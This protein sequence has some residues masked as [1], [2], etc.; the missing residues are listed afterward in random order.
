MSKTPVNQDGTLDFQCEVCHFEHFTKLDKYKAHLREH[1]KLTLYKCTFCDKS[2]S[3]SSN[4][5]KHKKIH[6]ESYLKCDLCHRKFN[7]KKMIALHMEYHRNNKPV[8]CRHCSR[9]FHFES[10]LKKHVKNAHHDSPLSKF[11]CSFCDEI[12]KSLREK[13]DHEWDVHNVRKLIVDCLICG[14]KFRK[15]SQLKRHCTD[16]HNLEIPAA[17]KLLMKRYDQQAVGINRSGFF[18]SFQGLNHAKCL[19]PVAYFFTKVQLNKPHN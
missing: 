16:E 19:I 5:S 17:K 1:A 18:V 9:V 7:S 3:D 8:K 13:W 14:R 15:Y 10:M 2:F 12:F 6:G 4:F 11:R